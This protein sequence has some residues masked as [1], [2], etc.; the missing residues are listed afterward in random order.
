VLL[1]A[2]YNNVTDWKMCTVWMKPDCMKG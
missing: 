1:Q 2:V